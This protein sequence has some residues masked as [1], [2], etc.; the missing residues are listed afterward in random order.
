MVSFQGTE[1]V[2]NED[3][4]NDLAVSSNEETALAGVDTEAGE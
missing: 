1:I 4:G 3:S 2:E